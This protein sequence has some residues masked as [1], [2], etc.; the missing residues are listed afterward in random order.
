MENFR[1]YW[2]IYRGSGFSRRRMIW[3]LFNPLPSV[4]C[5]GDTQED[6]ERKTCWRKKGRG[7]SQI[8][9][10]EKARFSINH[11]MLS[12]KFSSTL[13]C[14]R[15]CPDGY[16]PTPPPTY[17]THSGY[18]VTGGFLWIFFYVLLYYIQHCFICRVSDSTVSEYDG[19]EPRSVLRLRHW[20][21]DALTTRLDLIHH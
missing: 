18:L 1:E 20:L 21:S 2:M 12:G 14:F 5:T 15:I 6:F 17:C 19:I 10:G 3:L 8:T 4:R 9:Q 11:S 13:S 16:I 7:R